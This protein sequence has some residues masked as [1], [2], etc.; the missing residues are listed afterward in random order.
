L[1]VQSKAP[2]AE[3]AGVAWNVAQPSTGVDPEYVASAV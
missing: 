1:V 2:M 3:M